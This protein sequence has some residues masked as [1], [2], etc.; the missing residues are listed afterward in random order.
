[1]TDL[2]ESIG[3]G[4]GIPDDTNEPLVGPDLVAE[5]GEILGDPNGWLDAPNSL[6]MGKT[7][8]SLLGT[9]DEQIVRDIIARIKLGIFS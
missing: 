3:G 4:N 1:M 5:M 2:S 9:P 6:T 8:R 7:P